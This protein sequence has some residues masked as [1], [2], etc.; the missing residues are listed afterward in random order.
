MDKKTLHLIHFLKYI[1]RDADYKILTLPQYQEIAKDGGFK[2]FADN[3]SLFNFYNDNVEENVDWSKLDLSRYS[4]SFLE[5]IIKIYNKKAKPEEVFNNP[6]D[7]FFRLYGER[8]VGANYI[9]FGEHEI[10]FIFNEHISHFLCDLINLEEFD[11][12]AYYDAVYNG[13]CYRPDDYSED[14]KDAFRLIHRD[15]LEKIQKIMISLG[16]IDTAEKIK[17]GIDYSVAHEVSDKIEE[18]FGSSYND[19][20]VQEYR[21]SVESSACE[22]VRYS[23]DDHFPS[24]IS[25]NDPYTLLVTY[26]FFIDFLKKNPQVQ[27]FSDLRNHKFIDHYTDISDAQYEYNVDRYSLNREYSYIIDRLLDKIEDDEEIKQKAISVR[28]FQKII[29]QLKFIYHDDGFYYK[30]IK[31]DKN[32]FKRFKI[33][34]NIDYDREKVILYMI[35]ANVDNQSTKTNEYKI[36]FDELADYV[37]TEKLHET[38]RKAIRKFLL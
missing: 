36:P 10:D 2:N 33:S 29:Q 19:D 20:I 18:V 6:I 16:H 38:I 31:I 8:S 5:K 34:H 9:K 4:E 12:S 11:V 3:T 21:N 35:T 14:I 32:T 22:A 37:Y 15:N 27:T 26:D 24:D 30:D 13:S 7:D 1:A 28:K 23:F 17:D 25:L